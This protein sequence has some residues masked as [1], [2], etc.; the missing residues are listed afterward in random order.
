[1]TVIH[2]TAIVEQGAEIG[3][4]VSIGPFSYVA[5]NVKIGNKCSIAP[6]VTLHEYTSIG[7]NCQIHSGAVIGD[8]PQDIGFKG[9][10]SFVKIG[11]NCVIREGVT[12][13]RGSKENTITEIG[14]DCFL[15]AFSHFAHNVKIGNGVIAANGVLLAGH[16]EIGD[17]VFLS[18]NS[19]VH[20]FVKIGRLVML[21]GA[22]AVS[23]DVPPFCTVRPVSFNTVV[24][25]NV[26]GMRRAGI[27][28]QDRQ[29]IRRAFKIL[30][31]SGLNITQAVEKLKATFPSGPASE[32]ASFIEQSKRGLCGCKS[33]HQNTEEDD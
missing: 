16:V 32:F 8:L 27:N 5:G 1:M 30:Y 14:N 10:I 7:E 3:A 9:E 29:D 2:K 21:G 33:K 23:K 26:V 19:M 6:H 31:H 13:H 15:M 24:G 4:D 11:S 28:A 18:G 17:R 22:G 20:Q 12:I 25:L